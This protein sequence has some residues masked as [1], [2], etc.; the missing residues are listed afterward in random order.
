M[1]RPCL[2]GMGSEIER[3]VVYD[4]TVVVVIEIGVDPRITRP[5]EVDS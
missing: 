5:N 4:C 3:R 1:D 2:G